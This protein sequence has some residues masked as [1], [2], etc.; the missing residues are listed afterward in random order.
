MT[1]TPNP[2]AGWYPQGGQERWWNGSAWSDNFRPLGSEPTQPYAQPAYGQPAYGQPAYGQPAYGQPQFGTPQK[3]HVAR[4]L[5]IAFGLLF[6]LIVGG[7][8]AVVAVVGKSVNDAVNDDTLGGPNNPLTITEGQAFEVHGFEYA[9][10]WDIVDD[11]LGG[12]LEI[13]DLKVTNHRG[14]ADRLFATITL[15]NGNEIVATATC[16]ADGIDKIPDG[17]SATVDCSSADDLP[18]AYDEITIKDAF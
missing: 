15:L 10:G 6:L 2:P 16:T 3:S 11:P 12:L 9:A 7:C 14:K 4:N 13:E 1:Q 8:V 17:V 5:L 18:A